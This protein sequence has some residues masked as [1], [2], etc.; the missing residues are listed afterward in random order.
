MKN[1]CLIRL[2]IIFFYLFYMVRL[3]KFMYSAMEFSKLIEKD[4][5]TSYYYVDKEIVFL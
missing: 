2:T 1:N 4:K 5:L 3:T